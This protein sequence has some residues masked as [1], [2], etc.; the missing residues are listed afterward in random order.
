MGI[1]DIT[2]RVANE[3]E[4]KHTKDHGK[5]RRYPKPGTDLQNDQVIGLKDQVSPAGRRWLHTQ[6]DKA[7]AG[8]E[9]DEAADAGHPC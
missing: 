4:A 7:E 9:Q 3:V 6:A 2:Q 1:E 8:F 5:A